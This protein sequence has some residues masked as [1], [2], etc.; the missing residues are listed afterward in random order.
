MFS[1]IE[2]Y[3]FMVASGALAV[4]FY[5]LANL[6]GAEYDSPLTGHHCPKKVLSV[7]FT[8]LMFPF[9]IFGLLFVIPYGLVA[10]A[11]GYC[12][13]YHRRKDLNFSFELGQ[14]TS[15]PCYQQLTFAA[16]NGSQEAAYALEVFHEH[17]KEL[18]LQRAACSHNSEEARSIS[19]SLY[20]LE[21]SHNWDDLPYEIP[22]IFD[23]SQWISK[24]RYELD[25]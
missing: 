22:Y 11:C 10:R 19:R 7:I 13:G 18:E 2:P 24:K 15:K 4:I 8:A 5:L 3:L 25:F 16:Q 9:G 6:T 21:H 14:L 17:R 1:S 12:R 23:A 20:A